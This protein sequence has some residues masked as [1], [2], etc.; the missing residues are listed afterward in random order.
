[1]Q[2]LVPSPVRVGEAQ[3]DHMQYGCGSFRNQC[4]L[5]QKTTE[6]RVIVVLY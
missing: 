4:G 1:M 3:P 5:N 2:I 6:A